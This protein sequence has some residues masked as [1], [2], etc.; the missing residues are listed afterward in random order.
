[1]EILVVGEDRSPVKISI[2]TF[3]SLLDLKINSLTL[4]DLSDLNLTNTHCAIYIDPTPNA[5]LIDRLLKDPTSL[6][7]IADRN[8]TGN[9]AF[10]IPI[11]SFS[12]PGSAVF[13]HIVRS[14]DFLDLSSRQRQ[15]FQ[16]ILDSEPKKLKRV[17]DNIHAVEQINDRVLTEPILSRNQRIRNRLEKQRIQ[18]LALQYWTAGKKREYILQH[19]GISSRTLDRIVQKA[20]IS[21]PVLRSRPLITNP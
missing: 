18:Q 19:T 1:M 8:I 4:A 14:L 21:T 13:R 17:P 16:L 15:I 2:L 10:F 9:Q 3:L 20:K 12:N 7:L 11:D 6:I 5:N